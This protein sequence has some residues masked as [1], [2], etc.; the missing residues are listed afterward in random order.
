MSKFYKAFS[1]RETNQFRVVELVTESSVPTFYHVRDVL[2][3]QVVHV[4]R[5]MIEEF[6]LEPNEQSG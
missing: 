3:G 2:T 4:A 1:N 5:D 6:D